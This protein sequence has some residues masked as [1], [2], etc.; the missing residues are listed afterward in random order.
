M[1]AVALVVDRSCEQSLVKSGTAQNSVNKSIAFITGKTHT[2][3]LAN[4]STLYLKTQKLHQLRV[5][6]AQN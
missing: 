6:I 3:Q 5:S 1:A 4:K 2:A